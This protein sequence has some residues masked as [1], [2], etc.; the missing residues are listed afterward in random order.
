[1]PNVSDYDD[2]DK[3]MAACV[4]TRI[5]EGDEQKQAVAVCLNIWR[6]R[7]KAMDYDKEIEAIRGEWYRQHPDGTTRI[8]PVIGDSSWIVSVRSDSVIVEFGNTMYEVAYSKDAD[9]VVTFAPRTDW[10]EVVREYV[11]AKGNALKTISRTDAELRAANYIILFGGRDLEGVGSETINGDGSTGEYFTPE[12]VLESPYTK[13][14][15]LYVDWEHGQGELG[16]ELLGVVDW[17]TAHIDDKGV[18]VERVLNRRNQYVQWVEG[19]IDAGLIGTS[20]EADPDDVEKAADGASIRWPLRRDTLT[21][22]PMEPRM[23]TENHIQAFKA[24]GI[25]V[26]DDIEPDP[27]TEAEPEDAQASASVVE[28]KAKAELVLLDLMEV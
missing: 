25:P 26:P 27:Q 22:T 19:L 11:P 4:P 18:F 9:G 20:S 3:W 15:A 23:L 17:K 2:K 14:G 24:L 28:V 8:E 7:N 16:D 5:E 6:N 1:M 10:T 13:A 12:T 21:V